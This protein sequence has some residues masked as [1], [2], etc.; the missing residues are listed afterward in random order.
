[1][2]GGVGA[3][4][5]HVLP[6]AGY[7]AFSKRAGENKRATRRFSRYLTM[8]PR[9]THHSPVPSVARKRPP[10][11]WPAVQGGIGQ[12]RLRAHTH[13]QPRG[14]GAGAARMCVCEPRPPCRASPNRQKARKTGL[15]PNSCADLKSCRNRSALVLFGFEGEIL[16]FPPSQCRGAFC[17]QTR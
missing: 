6:R 11:A 15:A 17:F 3:S 16:L 4:D 1:M 10:A 13:V 7:D 12:W 14:R 2:A 8:P 5:M 9:R